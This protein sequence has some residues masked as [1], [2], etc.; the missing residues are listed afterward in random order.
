MNP[1]KSDMSAQPATTPT[2]P[3]TG[4]VR[5][6]SHPNRLANF[7]NTA[8]GITPAEALARAEANIAEIKPPGLDRID[9]L[10]R[11]LGARA[12]ADPTANQVQELYQASN[13]LAGIAAVFGLPALGRAAYSLCELLDVLG[14]PSRWNAAAVSVH[15][16]GMRLLRQEDSGAAPPE[17]IARVLDGLTAVV[18]RFREP[19]SRP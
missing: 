16:E 4:I 11:D 18:G 1:P 3:T 8:D 2:T 7:V 12:P 15:L 13:E 14:G 19:P 5:R 9:T 6:I 10:L 17:V